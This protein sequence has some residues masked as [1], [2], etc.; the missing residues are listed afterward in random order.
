ML[1]VS[2]EQ[3]GTV[4]AL[5]TFFR[6]CGWCHEPARHPVDCHRHGVLM[7]AI[8]QRSGEHM[9]CRLGRGL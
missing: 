3:I 2:V 8:R 1:E 5:L 7:A 6:G 9:D 4:G